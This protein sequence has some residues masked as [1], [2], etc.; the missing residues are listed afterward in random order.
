MYPITIKSFWF[1][2]LMFCALTFFN[3]QDS[4]GQ[5]PPPPPPGGSELWSGTS[6]FDGDS[7]VCYTCNG[8][9]D[10]ILEIC[11]RGFFDFVEIGYDEV[12]CGSGIITQDF[13]YSQLQDALNGITPLPGGYLG[14]SQILS[15]ILNG[16][17][18][19]MNIFEWDLIASYAS[20]NDLNTV[21]TYARKEGVEPASC[22]GV[23]LPIWL[24]LA[25]ILSMLYL[26]WRIYF[27]NNY[28]THF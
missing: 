2:L 15:A 17:L 12:P 8:W 24:N 11:W 10:P 5:V 3:A 18:Y 9:E 26:F 1:Y 7:G 21:C 23:P 22:S 14:F 20:G 28:G 13:G 25:I 6:E 4:Y 19:D 27:N 16:K